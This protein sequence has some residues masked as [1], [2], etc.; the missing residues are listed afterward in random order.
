[1]QQ[2][3]QC[4]RAGIIEEQIQRSPIFCWESKPVNAN[5]EQ[6][7]VKELLTVFT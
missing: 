2:Q 1:M 4:R 5:V 7:T 6:G 3:S